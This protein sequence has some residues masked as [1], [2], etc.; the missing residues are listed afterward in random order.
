MLVGR[1]IGKTSP[2]W[3]DFEVTSIIK[4]M[5]FIATRDPEKHWILGRIE[6]IV[7]EKEKAVAKVAV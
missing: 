3:F 6:G 4:K 1:I 5:D 7:Q 2:E